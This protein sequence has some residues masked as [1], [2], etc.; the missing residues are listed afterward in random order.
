MSEKVLLIGG[1][2][3]CNSVID[4]VEQEGM[5]EIAGI[6][7]QEALIGKTTLGYAYI[8]SDDDLPRLFETFKN[9][10]I[11]VGHVK[12]N[13]IRRKLFKQLKEIGYQLP[14]IISPYAYV[15]KHSKIGEGSVIMHH[16]LVNANVSIGHNCIINSKALIEHD[17]LIGDNC[18]IS[19][20]SVLNGGVVVKNDCFVGSN[21]TIVQSVVVD[22]FVKAGIIVK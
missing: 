18:H 22:G 21:S 6:I 9:A 14:V 17:C 16:A 7:D 13:K 2:G 12:S 1:G 4:V 5:F 19:T 20:N 10:V 3:H 8:G 11:C 15:S